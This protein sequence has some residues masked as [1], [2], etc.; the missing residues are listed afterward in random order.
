MFTALHE[1]IAPIGVSR[2]AYEK[3]GYGG[4][5]KV[6]A[7]AM[8]PSPIFSGSIA[9][10][11]WHY[12]TA[13]LGSHPVR[14]TKANPGAVSGEAAIR[15][16]IA[17]AVQLM[18]KPPETT[19]FPTNGE[20]S[21]PGV[22]QMARKPPALIHLLW[23]GGQQKQFFVRKD[24]RGLRRERQSKGKGQG[25]RAGQ[26]GHWHGTGGQN[27]RGRLPAGTG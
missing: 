10:V 9:C 19:H 1:R 15:P 24:L 5:P 12:L 4:G 25:L 3:G 8:P 22:L 26:A 16:L 7:R 20:G 23:P 2:T 6:L 17:K 11:G 27:I 13:L 14:R 18:S 21:R